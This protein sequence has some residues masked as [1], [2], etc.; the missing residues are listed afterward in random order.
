MAGLI[1][2]NEKVASSKNTE[3]TTFKAKAQNHTQV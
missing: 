2:N 3:R 1:V